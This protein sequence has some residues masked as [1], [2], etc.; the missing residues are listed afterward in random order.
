[1]EEVSTPLRVSVLIV[2]RNRHAA[3][4]RTL[5]SL[6]AS[7]SAA[8]TE[9]LV[10][11]NASTDGSAT[12]DTEFPGA[13]FLRMPRDFGW[14]KALNIA[15]RTAK[16]EYA[17]LLPP[18]AEIQ[19]DTVGRLVARLDADAADV[20][21]SLVAVCP[22]IESARFFPLP[23]AGRVKAFCRTG[24]PG[25]PLDVDLSQPEVAVEYPAGSPMM[26]RRR[27]IV[28]INY[29]DRRFGQYWSDAD[30]CAQIR[31]AGKRIKLLPG[32][33]VAGEP[34][35]PFG[36]T[37]NPAYAADAIA[38]GAAYLAKYHGV[39]VAFAFR[40]AAALASMTRPRVLLGVVT[41]QKVDG[42]HG[43]A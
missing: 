14:T 26:I 35:H 10:A 18:G 24:T 15:T 11:D 29:F 6:E 39:G 34:G 32:V 40:L 7:A 4:R 3:L 27:A 20:E 43:G 21:G 12:L 23:D 8:E 17:F 5:K 19:P 41:G 30:L 42:S 36:E 28:T 22:L 38:G 31:R 25:D 1:M 37:D 33:R 13:K 16:G 9:V 2:C